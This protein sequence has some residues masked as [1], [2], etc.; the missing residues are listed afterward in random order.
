LNLTRGGQG[1][2]RTLEGFGTPR[3]SR[4][5]SSL[6]GPV[7]WRMHGRAIAFRYV[8]A[9][10]DEAR[11]HVPP[12]CH[13]DPDPVVRA[14]FWDLA[15][16]SGWS[17]G[18]VPDTHAGGRED[19]GGSPGW[20]TFREAVVAFP[21]RCAGTAGDFPT[22]MFADDAV[23]NA[24][25]REVMGWPLRDGTIEFDAPHDPGAGGKVL[26]RLEYRSQTAVR[27]EVEL[28]GLVPASELPAGLPRWI[29]WKLIPEVD[30]RSALVDQLVETG[31]ESIDRGP[32]WRGRGSLEFAYVRG[33]ELHYL[34]PRSL[35]DVEYWSAISLVIGSGRVLLDRRPR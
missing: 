22:H 21:V 2:A 25:G 27:A 1:G 6:Y 14:R 26:A 5:T 4:G 12:E 8:L 32:V 23:Y 10:P 24:F 13:M 33:L 35:V 16:D 7:P 17:S 29:A 28:E 30:G 18:A 9:D 11:G 15:H 3:T 20:R 31:P 34:R 19:L